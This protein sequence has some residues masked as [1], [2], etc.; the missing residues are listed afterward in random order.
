MK[1]SNM[2]TM[3]PTK[4]EFMHDNIDA[5]EQYSTIKS[6]IEASGVNHTIDHNVHYTTIVINPDESQCDQY[7]TFLEAL[8]NNVIRA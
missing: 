6:M 5:L 4:F 8:H 3:T 7:V 2:N 1:K